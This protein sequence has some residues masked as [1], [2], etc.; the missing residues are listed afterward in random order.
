MAFA[1]LCGQLAAVWSILID[2]CVL[3]IAEDLTGCLFCVSFRWSYLDQ[4]FHMEFIADS[5]LALPRTTSRSRTDRDPAGP[6]MRLQLA[7]LLHLGTQGRLR[8]NP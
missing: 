7:P 1:M 8:R 2:E 3:E 6:F 5:S 4:S